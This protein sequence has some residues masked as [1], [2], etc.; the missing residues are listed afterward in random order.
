MTRLPITFALLLLAATAMGQIQMDRSVVSGGGQDMAGPSHR[1]RGTLGQAAIGL[2]G[3]G[4]YR[5]EVGFWYRSGAIA[6]SAEELP[7][8]VWSLSQNHPN[9]FNPS[10]TINFSLPAAADVSLKVYNARGE[11]VRT[12]LDA[13]LEAGDHAQEWRGRDDAGAAV[14]SGVY[15]ARLVSKHGVLTRKMVLTR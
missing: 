15:F 9:P 13:G 11:L 14:A 5:M 3:G 4:A 12:L 1:L 10:T 2:V 8:H 7:G 6:S